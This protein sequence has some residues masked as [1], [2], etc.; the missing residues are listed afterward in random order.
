MYVASGDGILVPLGV[1][2]NAAYVEP[3][4]GRAIGSALA[5]DVAVRL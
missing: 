4:E 5:P 2:V 1:L 3:V